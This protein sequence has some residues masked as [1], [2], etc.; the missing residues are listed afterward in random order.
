MNP[1]I[2][3]PL[4]QHYTRVFRIRYNERVASSF[5]ATHENRTILITSGHIIEENAKYIEIYLNGEFKKIEIKCMSNGYRDNIDA[6]VIIFDGINDFKN[7]TELNIEG[8]VVGQD[9]YFMGFPFDINSAFMPWAKEMPI[10]FV[11][12]GIIS[13]QDRITKEIY[14]D[15]INNSGF[16]GGPIIYYDYKMKKHKFAGSISGFRKEHFPVRDT[17]NFFKDTNYMTE[18]NSGIIHGVP[19]SS[20]K[21]LIDKLRL[22]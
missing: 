16:S 19:E 1:L 8:L 20:I 7:K 2:G 3:I 22:R 21:S 9:V 10:P 6:A 18:A 15:G 14:I 12:K 17:N 5:I 11:K 13:S 4:S